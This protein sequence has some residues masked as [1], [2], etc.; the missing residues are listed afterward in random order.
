MLAAASR[1]GMTRPS[2]SNAAPSSCR[3][4]WSSAS[5]ARQLDASVAA[6]S[7]QPSAAQARAMGG[8][9][10]TASLRSSRD[11]ALLATRTKPSRAATAS[12]A[13]GPGAPPA[14]EL[15]A[16][17]AAA[18]ALPLLAA[19]GNTLHATSA[20]TAA[21]TSPKTTSGAAPAELAGAGAA[22]L[23]SAA[24]ACTS[25]PSVST[26]ATMF[27]TIDGMSVLS[28]TCAA[29]CAA[30]ATTARY[31]SARTLGCSSPRSSMSS[32]AILSPARA[33]PSATTSGVNCMHMQQR[34]CSSMSWQKPSAAIMT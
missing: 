16:P 1:V 12:P 34:T 14:L 26:H 9:L 29:V 20:S 21:A 31:A 5:V 11:L 15:P 3:T 24:S 7:A 19:G 25:L 4:S 2:G 27:L 6:L 8:R 18:A 23:P 13:I 33:G 30:V 22:R 28:A 17:A 10:P 32:D